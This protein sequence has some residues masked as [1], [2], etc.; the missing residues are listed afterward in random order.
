VSAGPLAVRRLA[1]LDGE[2]RAR[3]L[4][5]A[6]ATIFDPELMDGVRE[7][8]EDV[9]AHGDAA[10]CRALAR[11]DGVACEPS[12]LRVSEEETAAARA[13]LDPDVVRAIRQGITN[14]RAFNKRV[15][16]DAS[17]T[18]EIAPGILVGERARPIA[19]A[20]LFVPSGKGSF[21]SVLMQI[22][23]P[24]VV[25]GV[26]QLAVV[27]PPVAGRGLEVDPAVL[28]VA[29]E[30]GIRDVF[31]ANG[32]AGIAALAVGTETIPRVWK[33]VGPGSP[34]VTAAQIQ[35]Q[36]LGCSTAM[37]FGPSESLVIADETADPR[38]LA[39]DV[40]NEAEHGLDSAA[41]LVT[42]SEALVEAVQVEAERQLAAL[43]EPRRSYAAAAVSGFGGAI[44]VSDL[45]EA[46]AFANEYAP[47]HLQVA[48]ADPEA[49][50]PLLDHAGEVL[51]GSTP[52][53]VANYVL[54]IPA[55][56]P[57]GG[58]ARVSS[59]V[60][61]RT[62][63]KT[64]SIGRTSPEALAR[65]APAVLALAEHE[66]FPAHSAAIRTRDLPGHGA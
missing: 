66:G 56:L 18:K 63:L 10:V 32:P 28:V 13:S 16:A 8:V 65:L 6:T 59:G 14:I 43:P 11:H 27:V 12:Q 62:F 21:P 22:G 58:F 9:R 30:L 47:E 52:F 15:L 26:P 40:L 1:D 39:A 25:A 60:N 61:A 48:T 37:L 19:S 54:G 24:A 44:V 20:G 3:I 41:L 38:T 23:T 50:L 2:E 45:K 55:T 46:C 42:P 34:A 57:T 53:A 51:L 49:L 5:R 36:L 35:V 17:W 64:S 33:V 29:D 7:I 31:R 4:A